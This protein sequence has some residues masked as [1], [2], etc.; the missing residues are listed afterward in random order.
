MSKKQ[1]Q[2]GDV[3]D[4]SI[5][6]GLLSGAGYM[7]GSIFGVIQE[8]NES[9]GA[10]VRAVAVEGVHEVDKL[11]TDDMVVGEKVNWNDTNKEVQEATSD[12]DGVGTV[13]EAAGV[14]VTTVKIKLTPV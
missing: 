10:A 11:S 6:D 14:G 7:V 1:Y 3:L 12:L 5:A 13:V 9:G 4:L 2:P 8:S